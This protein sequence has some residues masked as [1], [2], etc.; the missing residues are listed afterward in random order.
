[1]IRIAVAVIAV[2]L[3]CSAAAFAQPMRLNGRPVDAATA[4]LLHKEHGL[5]R[6]C[7]C[8]YDPVSGLV[9]TMGQPPAKQIPAGDRRFGAPPPDASG[10]ISG[11]VVNGR[12]ISLKEERAL[13]HLYTMMVEGE[14]AMGPDLVMRK[15][16]PGAPPFEYGR[17]WNAYAEAEE[18]ERKWCA[19]AKRRL[20]KS[21]PGESVLVED[22]RGT[23]RYAV[24]VV[25]DANG[26]VIASVQGEIRTRCC[27]E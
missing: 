11:V 18:A 13:E 1:M 20:A 26:C 4:D 6:D 19:D 12:A 8:W 5:P 2:S 15:A 14:Y 25:Q 3:A 16:Y 27:S 9:G 7:A 24:Q 17:A 23:G 21:R 10:W 22:A